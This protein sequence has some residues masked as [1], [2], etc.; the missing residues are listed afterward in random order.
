MSQLLL[1]R[2]AYATVV[3]SGESVGVVSS[4][5]V[6]VMRVNADQRSSGSGVRPNRID[7]ETG[8]EPTTTASIAAAATAA[9]ATPHGNHAA[10]GR[11]G[12]T[13]ST[14]ACDEEVDADVRV[15]SANARS[16]AD[17]KRRSGD[18]SRHRRT[19]RSRP[20]EMER[21]AMSRSGG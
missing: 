4:P 1:T 8:L 19:M 6:S 12:A 21:R 11:D 20:G 18:F 16:L 13:V 9:A 5:A 7:R 3:P 17:W 10:R 15:S 2:I 14:A